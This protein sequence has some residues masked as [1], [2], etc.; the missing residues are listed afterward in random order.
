M[1]DMKVVMRQ[2]KANG[3]LIDPPT[4]DGQKRH[5]L[6]AAAQ[7]VVTVTTAVE[8]IATLLEASVPAWVTACRLYVGSTGR[9]AYSTDG[10]DPAFSSGDVTHGAP[11]DAFYGGHL[12]TGSTSVAALKFIAETASTKLTIELI[13]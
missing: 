12:I 10:T 11:L 1:P 5:E 6:H 2:A 9:I 7:P 3:T 4:E 13:G 8:D